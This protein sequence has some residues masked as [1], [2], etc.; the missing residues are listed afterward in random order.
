MEGDSWESTFCVGPR[1]VGT[2]A[3]ASAGASASLEAA[4]P[5][6]GSTVCVALCGMGGKGAWEVGSWGGADMLD[7][8]GPNEGRCR[9]KGGAGRSVVASSC[10]FLST[11]SVRRYSKGAPLCEPDRQR[12]EQTAGCT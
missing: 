3:E 2:A 10:A 12:N 11:A 1:T 7:Y 8:E 6:K 4:C 5:R 9:E